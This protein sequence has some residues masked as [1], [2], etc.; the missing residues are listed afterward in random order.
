MH[1]RI[2]QGLFRTCSS[3]I[4]F[5]P[6]DSN[7]ISEPKGLQNLQSEFG[8]SLVGGRGTRRAN[9]PFGLDAA[10]RWPLPVVPA[11]SPQ[12][13]TRRSSTSSSP[14]RV[15]TI[16]C[17]RCLLVVSTQ[18]APV[19]RFLGDIWA[20]FDRCSK[21]FVSKPHSWTVPSQMQRVLR[22]RRQSNPWLAIGFTASRLLVFAKCLVP[23]PFA[24]GSGLDFPSQTLR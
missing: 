11:M 22:G 18:L 14:P 7:G 16:L 20:L 5:G 4:D 23:P 3:K 2:A 21:A 10:S 9:R 17:H 24:S 13:S 15:S 19:T 1:P 6:I 8:R 12:T